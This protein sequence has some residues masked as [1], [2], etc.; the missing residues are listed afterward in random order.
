MLI[1]IVVGNCFEHFGGKMGGL[2]LKQ[3]GK[4]SISAITCWVR[5]GWSTGH[6]HSHTEMYEQSMSLFDYEKLH[7][8]KDDYKNYSINKIL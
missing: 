6:S 4:F 8:E 2:A 3:M 5:L 1:K 7:L